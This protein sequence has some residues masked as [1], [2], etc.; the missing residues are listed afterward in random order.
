MRAHN[1]SDVWAVFRAKDYLPKLT[2]VYF[3]V[4]EGVRRHTRR[5]KPTPEEEGYVATQDAW[6]QRRRRRSTSQQ[7]TP[8]EECVTTQDAW[9]QRREPKIVEL[10]SL[11]FSHSFSMVVLNTTDAIFFRPLA[12]PWRTSGFRR[13]GKFEFTE[14][15][16]TAAIASVV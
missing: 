12:L 15:E 7:K 10:N 9:H 4:W 11:N 3:Y 5:V 13:R 6:N 2:V 8:E 14:E 16:N 1:G